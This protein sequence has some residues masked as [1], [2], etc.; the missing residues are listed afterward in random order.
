[1]SLNMSTQH[2][3]FEA[4]TDELVEAVMA[5]NGE[6]DAAC[7]G[8]WRETGG[9]RLPKHTR[10]KRFCVARSIFFWTHVRC[11]VFFPHL[12]PRLSGHR[13]RGR[14]KI[15]ASTQAACDLRTTYHRHPTSL[16]GNPILHDLTVR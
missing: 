7:C 13:E 3:F 11:F 4:G 12:R 8:A 2:R 10:N 6:D 1:M 16:H 5:I 9:Y 15:S 14:G